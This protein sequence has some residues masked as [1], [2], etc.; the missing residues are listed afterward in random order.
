[1]TSV[2]IYIPDSEVSH[3]Y[4]S[5][6]VFSATVAETRSRVIGF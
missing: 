5:K 4:F 1:M 2:F 6:M 3:N